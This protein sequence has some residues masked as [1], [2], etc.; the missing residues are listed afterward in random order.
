[1]ASDAGG[2]LIPS[3]WVDRVSQAP[4]G[5]G[6]YQALISPWSE[7]EG[8]L[9]NER[10][11]ESAVSQVYDMSGNEAFC[12]RLSET[13]VWAFDHATLEKDHQELFWFCRLLMD[14]PFLSAGEAAQNW[15][16]RNGNSLMSEG[17][18]ENLGT[19]LFMALHLALPPGTPKSRDFWL[20]WW[21]KAPLSWVTVI[22]DGLHLCDPV[23]AV[24]ELP[25]LLERM[26]GKYKDVGPIL[27][28]MLMIPESRAALQDWCRRNAKT[29]AGVT[30]LELALPYIRQ[31]NQVSFQP[32][33]V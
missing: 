26:G 29:P 24:E 32:D 33:P 31:E 14:A 7:T 4:A 11:V 16:H 20:G 9:I 15:L 1:M 13:V 3:S 23:R 12:H 5:E 17:Q 6:L 18:Y 30:I 10:S 28:G 19:F 22:Y 8:V 2:D 21:A 25:L 27:F